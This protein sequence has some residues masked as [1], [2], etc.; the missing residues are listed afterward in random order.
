MGRVGL[1]GRVGWSGWCVGTQAAQVPPG[2]TSLYPASLPLHHG[3]GRR[4]AEGIAAIR[5]IPE[6]SPEVPAS[7]PTCPFPPYL[8]YPPDPPY[9]PYPYLPYPPYPPYQPYQLYQPYLA[10]RV[11]N[12]LLIELFAGI[13]LTIV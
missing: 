3:E 12:C 2:L 11:R 9:L 4:S 10:A 6:N 5:Q 13:T 8:P 7:I 1:A